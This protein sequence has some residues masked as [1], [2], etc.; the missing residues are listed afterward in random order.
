MVSPTN[1]VKGLGINGR[2][3][4]FFKAVC[5]YF[6]VGGGTP[7]L[8]TAILKCAP[9]LCLLVCVL[10]RTRDAP[11]SQRGYG[12]AVCAGLALSVAGDA[13]L[14]WDG[15]A[16]LALGLGAFAAAHVAYLCAFGWR[17][18]RWRRGALLLA[19]AAAVGAALRP[20][21][22]LAPAVRAYALLLAA[23]AWR[24]TARP[25]R[26]RAGALLFL[27]SDA[28]LGYSLFGGSVPYKQV[29]VMST[30]YLGQL[31]IALSALDP[32]PAPV[33]LH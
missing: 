5:V 16:Q 19:A 33:A 4:P 22:A 30:Y 9:I 18:R 28:V 13:L 23:M 8:S 3:V 6:V 26:Q 21:E 12:R 27:L 32:P 14:V 11:S 15:E 25:G 29:V 17:P 24:G 7:S 2:L 10:L 20:P 1:F 31:G